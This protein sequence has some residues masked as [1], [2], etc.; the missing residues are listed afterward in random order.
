MAET[1]NPWK[2]A[3]IDFNYTRQDN[4]P[5]VFVKR[6]KNKQPIDNTG[7]TYKLEG[8]PAPDP[9]DETNQVFQLIGVAGGVD[10]TITF[11]TITG[12]AGGDFDPPGIDTVF[13]DLV[14][15][16]G[17]TERTLARGEITLDPRITDKGI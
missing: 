2:A 6:D 9:T 1:N 3:T 8:N 17:G 4:T 11:G 10:G 16:A 7:N 13:H 15:T 5:I 12:G 14:E